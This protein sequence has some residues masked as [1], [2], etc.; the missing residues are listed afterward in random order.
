MITTTNNQKWFRTQ[1]K[2]D[3]AKK[4]NRTIKMIERIFDIVFCFEG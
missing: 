1:P 2:K 4:I 3:I